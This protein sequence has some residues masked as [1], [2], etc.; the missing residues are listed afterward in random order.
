M[1]RFGIKIS[2]DLICRNS[3]QVVLMPT[4]A[5]NTPRH[6]T[7]IHAPE[8]HRL[9]KTQATRQPTSC[10]DKTSKSG[11]LLYASLESRL[12]PPSPKKGKVNSCVGLERNLAG[13]PTQSLKFC[14]VLIAGEW[15]VVLGSIQPRLI[16]VEWVQ[17][18]MLQK[19]RERKKGKKTSLQGWRNPCRNPPVRSSSVIL[20]A[21]D[22]SLSLSMMFS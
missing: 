2:R 11:F 19:W 20:S 18:E 3:R 13:Q 14:C 9:S 4:L 17:P 10:H 8:D 15:F 22:M 12:S 21:C 6:V 5:L 7:R 16:R 1:L